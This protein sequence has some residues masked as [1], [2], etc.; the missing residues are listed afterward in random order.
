VNTGSGQRSNRRLVG[1]LV[2]VVLAMFGF[3]YLLVPLYNVF[4]E[5]TGANG[6]SG[7]LTDAQ[8]RS[9]V[10]DE[11]RSVTVEF[12]ASLNQN[13]N[14][15]FY[16]VKRSMV[17]HPGRIY[18]TTFFAQNE[19]GFD[20]VGQAVPSVAPG[21]A[22]SYFNKTECF[23]FTNQRFEVG[24]GR[25]MPLRFVIDPALPERIQRVTLSYT[26]FDVTQTASRN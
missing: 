23:C 12:V 9:F 24:E 16:P 25:E 7:R 20:L 26:F 18:S 14:M 15:E 1:R 21:N 8:A 19:T 10:V 5:I 22:A 4:C 3:G 6:K 13:L 11:D 2:L 17:V